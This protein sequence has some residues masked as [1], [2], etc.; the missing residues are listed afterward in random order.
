MEMSQ[1]E[2]DR[3]KVMTSV[4]GGR[5]TQP[6]AV[7]SR[8]DP[9]GSEQRAEAWDHRAGISDHAAGPLSIQVPQWRR[10]FP[11]YLKLPCL[12]RRLKQQATLRCSA[13]D[14]IP[15]ATVDWR[16]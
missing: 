5:R 2:R 13:I 1:R 8:R 3:L 6:G 14:V 11:E 12:W 7:L 16:Y 9:A 15:A 10:R 4:Q